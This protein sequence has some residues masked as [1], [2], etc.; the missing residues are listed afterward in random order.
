M[1]K[2]LDNREKVYES[3]MDQ[4][5]A[6]LPCSKPCKPCIDPKRFSNNKTMDLAMEKFEEELDLFEIVKQNRKAQFLIDLYMKENQQRLVNDFAR[7]YIS[8]DMTESD[9]EEEEEELEEANKLPDH[10]DVKKVLE[11]FNKSTSKVDAL[12]YDKVHESLKR[13]DRGSEG[14]DSF[15]SRDNTQVNDDYE[16][17]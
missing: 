9:E 12:I 17:A 5:L 6:M 3:L 10:L 2:T 15:V 8:R 13:E 7:Y 14:N 11:G 16:A 4:K 1:M